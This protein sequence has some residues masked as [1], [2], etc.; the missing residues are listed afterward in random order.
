MVVG[1]HGMT[2]GTGDQ[3]GM[4]CETGG[5]SE[6]VGGRDGRHVRK[7]GM[8]GLRGMKSGGGGLDET[9]GWPGTMGGTEI[10]TLAIMQMGGRAAAMTVTL[11]QRSAN[12]M[13]IT[14]GTV[15][16]EGTPG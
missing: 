15:S 3:L 2:S 8:G 13:W 11:H 14:S 1:R 9:M 16:I 7:G 6:M 12:A 4:R 5:L 10:V